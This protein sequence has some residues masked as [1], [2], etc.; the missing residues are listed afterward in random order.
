MEIHSNSKINWLNIIFSADFLDYLE[1]NLLKEVSLTSKLIR[2]KIKPRLFRNLELSTSV[3]ELN[4]KDNIF[5]EYINRCVYPE[6]YTTTTIDCDNYLNSLSVEKS[7]N[8]FTSSLKD[9]K[10]FAKS[11]NFEE[12]QRAEYYLF[13]IINV[14]DNLTSLRLNF[15]AAPLSA[16]NKLGESLNNLKCLEVIDVT[17]YNR[18]IDSLNS[19]QINIPINLSFLDISYLAIVSSN[20][21]LNPHEFL[22]NQYPQ[23]TR[24]NFHLSSASIPTLKKLSYFNDEDINSE[25]YSFLKTNPNLESL[26]I[27]SL[28][29]KLTNQ[30]KFIKCL[31]VY[32]VEYINTKEKAPVLKNTAKLWVKSAYPEHYENIMKLCSICPN[33]TDLHLTMISDN[34]VQNSINSFLLPLVSSLS[35]LK[36]LRLKFRIKKVKI[37]LYKVVNI[38]SLIIDTDEYTILNLNFE[39][40]DKLKKIKLN[41]SSEKVNTKEFRDKFNSYKNW[42]FRFSTKS[43]KGYRGY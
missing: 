23:E 40:S 11:L 2:D 33:L 1:L 36:T 7:L 10:M 16:F 6:T 21:L 15:I 26:S 38:E 27:K 3:F 35:L 43:I 19:D 41:S 8:D 9:I 12:A 29:D 13:P 31:E 20:S 42:N 5:I 14:F 37:M 17:L 4:F 24:R 32:N 34:S 18:H 22:L 39:N 25:L 28:S 30:L